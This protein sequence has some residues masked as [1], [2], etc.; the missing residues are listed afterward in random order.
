[1]A[2]EQYLYIAKDKY[3]HFWLG[4]IWHTKEEVESNQKNSINKY[5]LKVVKVKLVEEK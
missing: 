5:K 3:S 2:K 4:T 1:M